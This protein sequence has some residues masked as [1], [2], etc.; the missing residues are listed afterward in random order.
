MKSNHDTLNRPNQQTRAEPLD[1]EVMKAVLGQLYNAVVVTEAHLDPPGPRIVYANQAFARLTGYRV[2]ELIGQTPRILQGPDTD[3]VL[4]HELRWRLERGLT[5]EGR[6]TNYRKGGHP[7]HVEWNISPVRNSAGEIRHFISV[8]HDVTELVRARSNLVQKA[9]NDA[10]TGLANRNHGEELLDSQ[11]KIARRHDQQ[12]SLIMLDIDNFKHFND[13]HGHAVGDE[14]LK[15]V[16]QGLRKSLRETDTPIR[17]GGE[18]FLVLLPYNDRE[19]A[20]QAAERIHATLREYRHPEAGGI[21][22]SMGVATY[23][24]GDEIKPLIERADRALYRAKQNG[25]NRTESES[26]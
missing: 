26:T 8:Q 19:G 17:W 6:T 22:A 20:L 2:K 21:T 24:E 14:V 23:R 9:N 13:Q 15:A 3:P 1:L 25:R 12:W 5:F 18:E 10:L 7:Y 4:L 11:A 16:A